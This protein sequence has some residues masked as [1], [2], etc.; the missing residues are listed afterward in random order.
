MQRQ[1]PTVRH[2]RTRTFRTLSIENPAVPMLL[3]HRNT[4]RTGIHR[5]T[6][7]WEMQEGCWW[8]R[9]TPTVSQ[10]QEIYRSRS[11]LF[12]S[13]FLMPLETQQRVA[14]THQGSV[15]ARRVLGNGTASSLVRLFNGLTLLITHCGKKLLP[16]WGKMIHCRISSNTTEQDMF[17]IM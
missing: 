4:R 8:R 3:I 6:K 9:R 13:P 17:G 11:K 7:A 2:K 16:R 14:M 15:N 10:T 1:T 5:P 12:Q